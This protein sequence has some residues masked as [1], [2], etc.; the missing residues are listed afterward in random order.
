MNHAEFEARLAQCQTE[1]ELAVLA[2]TVLEELAEEDCEADN[3]PE[4]TV[5][6]AKYRYFIQQLLERGLNPAVA[7]EEDEERTC[8]D[9][10]MYVYDDAVLE[11]ARM[12]F[13]K[14]GVP[15]KFNGYLGSKMDLNQYD[16][17]QTVKLYLLA[18]AYLWET[19]ET[20]LQMNENLCVEMFHGGY[21]WMWPEQDEHR[22]EL[23]PAIFK[24]IEKYD[25]SVEYLPRTDHRAK[26]M[27]HIFE[28]ESRIEIAKYI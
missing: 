7:P 10:L 9:Y 18:S 27:F 13:E 28:K 15:T 1:R 14:C 11:I 23:T 19:E 26:W 16:C 5:D 3:F 12:I 21:L 6:W 4:Q 2:D 20:Y 8:I 22:L 17:P 24:E 25:F